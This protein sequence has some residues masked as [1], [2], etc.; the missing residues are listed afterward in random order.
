VLNNQA[1]A[2]I[3]GPEYNAFANSKGGDLRAIANV[4]DRG[5]V[6]LVSK[7][8]MGPIDQNYGAYLK[9]K[10]IAIQYY[11]STPNSI[12]SSL[13]SKKWGLDLKTDVTLVELGGYPAILAALKAGQ[14]QVGAL[15]EPILTQAQQEDVTDAPFFSVPQALGPYTY[16]ALSVRQETITKE[17]KTVEGFVRAM[18]KAQKFVYANTD[19]AVAIAKEEFPTMAPADMKATLERAIHDQIWSKNG[20]ISKESW[21]TAKS[22]VMG[23]DVLKTDV[24]YDAIIDMSFVKA[25]SEN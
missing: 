12:V 19:Q 4:I 24:S 21:D 10:S 5:D 14:A 6:Y 7:K 16:S 2:C 11:G 20:L 9:G 8:G 3:G 1:F 22:V 23:T 13:A 25:V 15:R 17:P 18:V